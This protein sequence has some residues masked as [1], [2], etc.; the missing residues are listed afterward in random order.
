MKK[1]FFVLLLCC[2]CVITVYAHPG[3]LQNEG[4]DEQGH[5]DQS[6]GEYHYHHSNIHPGACEYPADECPLNPDNLQAGVQEY[7][8]R[9]SSGSSSHSRSQSSSSREPASPKNSH[10]ISMKEIVLAGVFVIGFCMIISAL[11]S[12][13]QSYPRLYCWHCGKRL[14]YGSFSCPRCGA[15]VYTAADHRS[16]DLMR[17]YAQARNMPLEKYLDFVEANVRHSAGRKR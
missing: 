3:G 12:G 15:R 11:A 9:T 16:A 7:P 2:A 13:R 8:N 17:K 5:Y 14:S 10:K 4:T 1:L 6:A